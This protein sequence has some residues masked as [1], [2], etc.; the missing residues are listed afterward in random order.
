MAQCEGVSQEKAE[1]SEQECCGDTGSEG[2]NF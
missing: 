1:K 2:G